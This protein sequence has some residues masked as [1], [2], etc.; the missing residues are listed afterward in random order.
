MSHIDTEQLESILSSQGTE[1]AFSE[2][3]K[4][5]REQRRLHELF[6][7]RLMQARLRLGLPVI[8]GKSQELAAAD[9]EAIEE[10]YMEACR[11]T[12]REW[13]RD[14][15][16]REAWMYLRASGDEYLMRDHL[17]SAEPDESR[18]DALIDVALHEGVSPRQGLA[19]ILEHYGTCNAI[20]S[21]DNFLHGKEGPDRARCA[22]LLVT[23]VYEELS[24]NV[25]A[26]IAR[27]DERDLAAAT[28]VDMIGSRPELLEGQNYH[29]DT[30]HLHGAVRIARFAEELKAIEAAWELTEY[31]RRLDP[32]YQFAGEEPFEDLYPSHGLFFAAQLGRDVDAALD[33]FRQQARDSHEQQGPFSSIA[34]FLTLLT[35]VGRLE[36]AVQV[37]RDWV[38]ESWRSAPGAP[39]LWELCER[40]GNFTPLIDV[41][42]EKSDPIAYLAGRV[43]QQ[44]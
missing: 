9:Q 6:E 32:Q 39:S 30:T 44:G 22:E 19:W 38:P 29:L 42:R 28:L 10:A 12:G 41:A 3:A 43:A 31:G 37:A 14:G 11:E 4:Q 35:R 2:L 5:L 24:R 40:L 34:V 13:L 26:D 36:E 23:H 21:F 7:V 16:V 15:A 18:V 33:Y 27:R 17:A 8:L 20:T 25:A 1:A